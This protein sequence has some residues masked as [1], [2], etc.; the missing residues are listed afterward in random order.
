[1]ET[2]EDPFAFKGLKYIQEVEESQMLLDYEEPCVIIAASGMADAGRVRHHIRNTIGS[3]SNTILMVGYCDPESLGGQLLSG[4]EGVY[5]NGDAYDVKAD[6]AS[7]KSLSAH[8]DSNDLVQ[9]LA[10]QDPS[11][12]KN[13]FLVHGERKVQE[14][15][16]ET[17]SHKGFKKISIPDLHETVEL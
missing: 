14:G 11:S 10:S 12:V 16:R 7:I 6:V 3:I 2:D 13:I 8:G 15:F 9:F 17:L 5:M 4:K 1:M